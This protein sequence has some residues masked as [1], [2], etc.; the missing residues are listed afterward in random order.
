[1]NDVQVFWY[2]DDAPPVTKFGLQSHYFELGERSY[3]KVPTRGCCCSESFFYREL[4]K[5]R[6]LLLFV[7]SCTP[8]PYL[9]ACLLFSQSV[10]Y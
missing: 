1:M 10:P 7:S 4:C 5:Q 2:A 9:I 8:L 3:M 6:G